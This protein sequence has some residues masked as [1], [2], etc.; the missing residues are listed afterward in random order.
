MIVNNE[1]I[2]N[3]TREIRSVSREQRSVNGRSQT[4]EV[5]NGPEL[6]LVQKATGHKFDA[7]P[8]EKVDRSTQNM[9]PAELRHRSTESKAAEPKQLVE[10][11]SKLQPEEMPRNLPPKQ[12]A[13]PDK[14]DILEDRKPAP[15]TPE[16]TVP[17]R[18]LPDRSLQEIPAQKLAPPANKE[19]DKGLPPSR[20]L[21]PPPQSPH[22]ATPENTQP[23]EKENDQQNHP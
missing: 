23:K 12:D 16:K 13:V 6:A 18:T 20:E 4:V 11:Q 9:A 19:M 17:E 7:V 21:N 5:N 3:Q 10:P 22:P 1:T 2:I 14:R 8:V 15:S